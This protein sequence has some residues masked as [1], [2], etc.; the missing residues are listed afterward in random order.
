MTGKASQGDLAK[1]LDLLNQE[2]SA[3]RQFTR[4]LKE[5]NRRLGGLFRLACRLNESKDLNQS[6]QLIAD[7]ARALL[8]SQVSCIALMDRARGMLVIGGWSDERGGDLRRLCGL[9]GFFLHG[10]HLLD[11][12]EVAM[13]LIGGR[14]VF[15]GTTHGLPKQAGGFVQPVHF[16]CRIC[17]LQREVRIRTQLGAPAIGVIAFLE[18][19]QAKGDSAHSLP[20]FGGRTGRHRRSCGF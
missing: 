11:K 15:S 1:Q 4:K 16:Q 17:G 13:G 7:E 2:L 14:G 6:L 8:G 9:F 10:Q 20:A 19:L 5:K 18:S 3:Q 12:G